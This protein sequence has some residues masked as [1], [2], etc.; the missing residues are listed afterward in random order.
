MVEKKS[1][2][3]LN[4]YR[5]PGLGKAVREL[6]ALKAEEDATA[7]AAVETVVARNAL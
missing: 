3:R 2:L 7:E 5:I 6:E 4:R 1:L